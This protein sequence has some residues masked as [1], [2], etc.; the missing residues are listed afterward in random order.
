MAERDLAT[1]AVVAVR[2]LF[3]AHLGR[4]P[5][6]ETALRQRRRSVHVWKN[7]SPVSYR[8]HHEGQHATLWV[9]YQACTPAEKDA[10]FGV[11]RVSGEVVQSRSVSDAMAAASAAATSAFDDLLMTRGAAPVA[12]R[13]RPVGRP[14]ADGS[15]PIQWSERMSKRL[16]ELRCVF[17][18]CCSMVDDDCRVVPDD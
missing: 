6:P 8:R 12:E 3:C 7:L 16:V 11:G 18:C 15:I 1:G 10:F 14:R 17:C 13:K 5:A 9:R 4:D 2:C